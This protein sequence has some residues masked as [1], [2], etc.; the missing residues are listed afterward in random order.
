MNMFSI[1]I[2]IPLAGNVGSVEIRPILPTE[3]MSCPP[4]PMVCAVAEIDS[5][6]FMA[7]TPQELA[8][9]FAE[10]AM[11]ALQNSLR[12]RGF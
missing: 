2:A 11:A 12:A 5:E 9:R 10:P 8:I 3:G 7:C 1:V 6:E 4:S